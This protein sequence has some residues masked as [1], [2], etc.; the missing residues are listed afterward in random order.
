[1]MRPSKTILPIPAA[2]MAIMLAAL[3]AI[4]ATTLD[5][6]GATL[7][8]GERPQRTDYLYPA[9]WTQPTDI[10][11]FNIW[12]RSNGTGKLRVLS[13]ADYDGTTVRFAGGIE[14]TLHRQRAGFYAHDLSP[15]QV[16][17]LRAETHPRPSPIP[18]RQPIRLSPRHRWSR[19]ST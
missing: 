2:I 3:P 7:E 16:N 19:P 6:T 11:E 17:V 12:I 15:A 8:R 9:S 14:A 1:M 13:S 10:S 4:G 18:H 5:L